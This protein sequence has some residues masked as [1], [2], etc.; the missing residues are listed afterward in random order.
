VNS[1]CTFSWVSADFLQAKGVTP[2]ADMPLWVPP[3]TNISG[4]T[5]ID[6]NRAVKAGLTFRPM[7]LTVQDSLAWY[8]AEPERP[9]KA[10]LPAAREAALLREWAQSQRGD[11]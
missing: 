9:L 4:L 3:G 1:D 11:G 7:A 2:W 6:I 10:G 5:T 8:R